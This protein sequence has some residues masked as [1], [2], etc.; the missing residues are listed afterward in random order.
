MQSYSELPGLDALYLEDSY[1]LAIHEEATEVR[2]ELDAVMTEAHPKWLSP[3]EGE[4]Y[5]YLRVDLVFPRVERLDWIEKT[6]KPIVGPDAEV[7]YG[8]IDGFTWG[9]RW[10][11]L[12]GE[13]GH[14]R[15]ES[16]PPIVN[17]R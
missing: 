9:P 10:Y 7:D 8:N 17:E 6:M 5:A 12:H 13:W 1:V 14:V 11:E 16:G 4:A 3:K 2:F 15:I